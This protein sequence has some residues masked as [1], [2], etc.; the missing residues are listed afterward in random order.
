MKWLK[1]FNESKDLNF[2]EIYDQ[3]IRFIENSMINISDDFDISYMEIPP[4]TWSIYL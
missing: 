2:E 3:E 4:S 1:K